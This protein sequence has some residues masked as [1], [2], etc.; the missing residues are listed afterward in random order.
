MVQVDGA[1]GHA[2]LT[3]R[4]LDHGRTYRLNVQADALAQEAEETL[5]VHV[6]IPVGSSA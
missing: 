5:F 4:A 6:G 3:Q 1:H 2:T